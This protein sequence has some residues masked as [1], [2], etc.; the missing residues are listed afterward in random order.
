VQLLADT[1][2]RARPPARWS[3]DDGE[4]PS[5]RQTGAQAEPW[6][7]VGPCP[8]VHSDLTPLIAL[9]VANEQS[10]SLRIESVS[11]SASA[12]LIRSAARHR[13]TITPRSLTP[14]RSCP[15]ACITAMI[16]STVGGSGGYRR[17]LLPGVTLD[18]MAMLSP[19]IGAVRRDPT[20]VWT[21]WHPRV[22]DG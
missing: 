18:E 22:D 13:T 12:S 6:F 2:R 9:A 3:A 16:S 21:A 20:T 17:P 11:L 14:S 5:D 8:A 19:V 7:E 1:G 10:S 15:A 4:Q